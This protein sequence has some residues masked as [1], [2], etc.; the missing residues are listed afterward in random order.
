MA[1]ALLAAGAGIAL[2]SQA[3]SSLVDS[4]ESIAPAERD[5]AISGALADAIG[6]QVIS[7]GTAAGLVA[8]VALAGFVLAVSRGFSKAPAHLRFVA[9]GGAALSTAFATYAVWLSALAGVHRAFADGDVERLHAAAALYANAPLIG[10]VSCALLGL[11]ALLSLA[12]STVDFRG[13]SGAVLT[14]LA[15][16]GLAALETVGWSEQEALLSEHHRAWSLEALSGL[17]LPY[18]EPQAIPAEREDWLVVDGSLPAREIGDTGWVLSASGRSDSRFEQLLLLGGVSLS[19]APAEATLFVVDAEEVELRIEGEVPQ[20]IGV[21]EDAAEIL[22]AHP[23]REEMVLVPGPYWS[24]EELLT[25]CGAIG[26]CRIA[27]TAPEPPPPPVTPPKATGNGPSG[28]VPAATARNIVGRYQG[29]VRYCYEQALKRTNPGN[30]VTLRFTVDNAGKVSSAKASG[31]RDRQFEACV[32]RRAR[33]WKFPEGM[34]GEVVYPFIL[35]SS[36]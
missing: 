18:G 10:A 6:N 30:R 16:G 29:Q 31:S 36:P 25:L 32:E 33:T 8:V 5:A 14:L 15:V 23:Q 24:V 17:Q 1:P 7:T 22:L 20:A 2:R 9:S 21:G 3:S 11:V 13:L 4:L 35:A 12:G 26:R 27:H 19:P 34:A 28:A